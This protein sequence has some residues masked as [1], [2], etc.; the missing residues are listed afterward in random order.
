MPHLKLIGLRLQISQK[1]IGN[2]QRIA[3]ADVSDV[4]NDDSIRDSEKY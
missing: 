4:L 3:A 2:L 1:L